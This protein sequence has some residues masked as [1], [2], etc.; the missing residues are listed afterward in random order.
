MSGGAKSWKKL[1]D[2]YSLYS[3]EGRKALK[4]EIE[5]QLY[6]PGKYPGD[7]WFYLGYHCRNTL[8][9]V[10]INIPPATHTLFCL[11]MIEGDNPF[12]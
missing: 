1:L 12:V 5:L 2:L 8:P 11:N 6:S 4:P 10:P 7:P 9:K 3:Q